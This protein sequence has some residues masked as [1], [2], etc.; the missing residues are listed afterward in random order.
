LTPAGSS[1]TNL[2]DTVSAASHISARPPTAFSE[3]FGTFEG[4]IIIIIIVVV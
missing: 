2:T 3:A 1:I 4:F